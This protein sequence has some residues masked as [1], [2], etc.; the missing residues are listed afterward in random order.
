MIPLA[1]L[2]GWME[3]RVG[4]G[5]EESQVALGFWVTPCGLWLTEVENWERNYL[6]RGRW[7]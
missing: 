5:A 2:R 1:S 3:A 6:T 4:G 7:V